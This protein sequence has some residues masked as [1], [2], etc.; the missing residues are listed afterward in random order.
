LITFW[1][2]RKHPA[3]NINSNEPCNNNSRNTIVN[4]GTPVRE[5]EVAHNI[6]NPSNSVSPVKLYIKT[7]PSKRI[8]EDKLP[9]KKYFNPAEV[10]DSLSRYKEAKI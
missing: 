10:A 5:K 6:D 2:G 7:T 3:S 9:N 4:I 1:L 8:A